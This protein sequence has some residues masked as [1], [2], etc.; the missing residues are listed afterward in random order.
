MSTLVNMKTLV[1]KKD[2]LNNFP[3]LPFHKIGGGG[4]GGGGFV[5]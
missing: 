1:K 2:L 4:G 5:K 3:P